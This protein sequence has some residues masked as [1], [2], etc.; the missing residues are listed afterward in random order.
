MSR[1]SPRVLPA[2]S[3]FDHDDVPLLNGD[4]RRVTRIT[5][6]STD[7][8]KHRGV[9]SRQP[10]ILD[11]VLNAKLQL[12]DREWFV[13][14]NQRAA[15]RERHQRHARP[16]LQG[17]RRSDDDDG[18]PTECRKFRGRMRPFRKFWLRES[19]DG[20]TQID[21]DLRQGVDHFLGE[22]QRD[23][24]RRARK[25]SRSSAPGRDRTSNGIHK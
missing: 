15:V 14:R 16:L 25:L 12:S 22:R 5:K 11:C 13:E 4:I 17:A 10:R 20:S 21:I 19:Y 2:G 6:Q 7:G 8:F 3:S 24:A 9:R 23:R 18:A 1:P